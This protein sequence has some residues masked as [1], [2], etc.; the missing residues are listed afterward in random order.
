MEAEEAGLA[1]GIDLKLAAYH[2]AGHAVALVMA[3][4]DFNEVTI[5]GGPNCDQ[6]RVALPSLS[7]DAPE[8]AVK[9]MVRCAMGGAAAEVCVLGQESSV[10]AEED[11]LYC[12]GLLRRITDPSSTEWL[13]VMNALWLEMQSAFACGDVQKAV[14]RVADLLIEQ[15]RISADDA[16]SATRM[17]GLQTMLPLPDFSP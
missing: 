13:T 14:H 6:N 7:P 17:T 1:E 10:G 11:H 5:F 12:R 8:D 3:G 15:G 9:Q 2:E 16:R 4:L